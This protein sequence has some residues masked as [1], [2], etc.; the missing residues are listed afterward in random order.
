MWKERENNRITGLRI[1]R[2]FFINFSIEYDKERPAEYKT[3]SIFIEFKVVNE[4][5]LIKD[6]KIWQ[7]KARFCSFVIYS[8]INILDWQQTFSVTNFFFVIL[9]TF[10]HFWGVPAFFWG[11]TTF[12]Q[13]IIFLC[14]MKS[15]CVLEPGDLVDDSDFSCCKLS[16]FELFAD[17]KIFQH[18][19]KISRVFKS[20]CQ[21]ISWLLNNVSYHFI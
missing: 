2:V 5:R 15:R 10:F 3:E 9:I 18:T 21:T 19:T 16:G 7:S 4:L 1:N 14:A 6:L 17:K 12:F 20:G 8:A 13:A 11:M